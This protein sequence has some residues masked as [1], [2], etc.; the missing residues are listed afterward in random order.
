MPTFFGFNP[1]FINGGGSHKVL[2]TQTDERLIKNDLLQ[3]LLTSP[4]ERIYQPDFGSP[5]RYHTFENFDPSDSTR[6]EQDVI[7]AILRFEQRVVV[8]SVKV[9]SN[10][11]SHTLYVRVDVSPINNPLTN[12]IMSINF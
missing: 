3:L 11:D 12:Y 8:N 7:K 10:Q 6:L 5:L 9:G 4:G 1:P 2:A